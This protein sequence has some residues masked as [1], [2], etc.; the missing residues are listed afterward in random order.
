MKRIYCI[1]HAK[2]SWSDPF[3]DD[4]DSSKVAEFE[5]GLLEYMQANYQSSLDSIGQTGVISD[6]TGA[7]LKKAIEEFKKGFAG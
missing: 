1:R 3:L 2:S 7:E 6:E 4:I 5:R